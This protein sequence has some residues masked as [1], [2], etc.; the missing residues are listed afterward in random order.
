MMVAGPLLSTQHTAG[1][2]KRNVAEAAEQEEQREEFEAVRTARE[3]ST[4]SN[5]DPHN[6]Q[7]TSLD[8]NET[9]SQITEITA[10]DNRGPLE[11]WNFA[12]SPDAVGQWASTA[13]ASSEFN[14]SY[15]ATQATGAPNL[16]ECRDQSGA[17]A[18]LSS[19]PD[20]EWLRLGYATPVYATGVRIH[21]TNIGG[22]VTGLD[23]VEPNG[24]VHTLSIAIDNTVCPGYFEL[25]FAQTPYL[26]A[27]II[28]H[29]QIAG[30]EEID[31]VELLGWPDSVDDGTDS[32]GDGISDSDELIIGTDPNKTDTDGD[33]LT[34][35]Q[36]V[37]LG[38]DPTNPDTDGDEVSD[39]EE[40]KPFT[41]AGQE[42][43]SDPLQLDTN[44]DGLT[45]F[46]ERT[47]D[48]DGDLR[49]DDTDGDGIPD[50]Y[51]PDNDGDL[52]P[53]RIDLS[54]FTYAGR[55]D[56]YHADKPFE[57]TMTGLTPGDYTF[58][59]LQLRPTDPEHLWYA[60]NVLDWPTDHEG[61]V[62]DWDNETFADQLTTQQQTSAAINED[63]GDM[64]LT[65]MLEIRI[66]GTT[67]NMPPQEM[68]TA[69]NISM[70][71]LTQ[72][73]TAYT[74]VI[75]KVVYV[76]L[77]LVSDDAT[78]GRAAFQR[79]HSLPAHRNLE[80]RPRDAHGLDSAG[81]VRHPLRSQRPGIN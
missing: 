26:V 5:F 57:L 14:S 18:P 39:G 12:A 33:T 79:P 27:E 66:Y 24:T 13:S 47:P 21:E 67:T 41:Y 36:E 11:A 76:P 53:D 16:T 46:Q 4:Q 54:P 68:L 31:A 55:F 56:P 65:P 2:F 81:L 42:W 78:G 62:Q 7:L 35:F 40:V 61:Q 60:Y 3:Q 29:T 69:Y 10:S 32:D 37:S 77:V 1:F 71:D 20:P 49:P 15:A 28:V 72:D 63:N 80:Q 9:Q 19:G 64:R 48:F 74:P 30:W 6:D 75:G 58:L 50:L 43:A 38:T 8:L 73:G 23:L 17:W 25:S 22:F 59:D 45:D 51:D 44:K 70:S 52:V 34:D